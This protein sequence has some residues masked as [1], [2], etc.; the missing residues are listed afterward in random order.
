MSAT[1]DRGSLIERELGHYRIVEKIGD[2]GM[3]EVFRAQD[4][5]LGHDVALKVLSPGPDDRARHTFRKEADALS[6]LNHPNIVTVFDFDTQEGLDFLVMEYV[7]GVALD[8]KVRQGPLPERE[9]VRIGVQLAQGLAAA[10]ERGVIHRD[11]K[12]G[13]LR[14]TD[15]DRLKILDFG[16]AR[17]ISCLDPLAST[18]S[19]AGGETLAGTVRYMAPEQ[20]RGEAV[21]ARTDI[22]SAGA[23]LH[24]LATGNP[25]FAQTL[26]PL[27]IDDILHH[28]P[29]IP[30]GVRRR[31]SPRFEAIILKCLAKEPGQRYQS[32]KDLQAALQQL[33]DSGL[34]PRSLFRIRTRRLASSLL[35]ALFAVA[36]LVAALL[37]GWK[38]WSNRAAT[39]SVPTIDAL[40]VLPLSNLSGDPSQD[41]LA[42][43]MTE[44]LITDLGQIH[45]FDRIISFTSAMMFKSKHVPL[46]EI[47]RQLQVDAVIEGS[48]VRSEKRVQVTI[49][50]VNS[51]DTQLWS[52][53][54]QREFRDLLTLQGELTLAIAH[55][56]KMNVTAGEKA[57]LSTARPVETAA[58]EAYFKAKY[59]INGTAEQR[60]KSRQYFEQA[61]QLDPDY[62]AAYAGLA[63]SYWIDIDLPAR[64]AMPKA[65]KYALKAISLDENLAHAHTA[66]ASVR[67]YGDW[68]WPGADREYQRA[69]QLNPNDAE[70]RR[71]YSVFL[72][73]MGRADQAWTQ[74]Q[75]A[76]ELDPLYLDNATTAG[77]VLYCAHQYDQA[78]GQCRKALELAPNY[79]SSHAC[80]SYAYL[81]KGQRRQAL[82]EGKKAW[83]LSGESIRAVLLGR[84]EAA[85]GNKAE[86]RQILSRLLARSRQTYVPPYFVAVLYA[87][88][89][90]N[91]SALQ[92]LE[93]AYG[94]RDLYLAWIKVDPAVDSLRADVRFQQLLTKMGLASG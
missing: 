58:Q 83:A 86:A 85:A 43:G 51:A 54:Y 18:E 31:I 91:A 8:E 70:A 53:T 28:D 92:W 72:S 37:A 56:I 7:P 26:S 78:M 2:G 19:F 90:D 65:R 93:K 57:Q 21:D 79:D 5:H 82:D 17:S 11:L 80:M 50:L 22:Y 6:K 59:L 75:T 12:P 44:S 30:D 55:E 76:Q 64:E 25:P 47:A 77:W 40:A 45:A 39:Q 61:V 20:L 33:A 87:A 23:V 41:Y 13:N 73:A 15:D 46:P 4:K 16:L 81:G 24:E 94:E 69:L 1:L 38:W 9:A 63:D 34:E 14:L 42:D 62:A 35:M 60:A 88:L 29:A 74:L 67:F 27:L 52:H 3:G 66:L 36:V 84:T 10:H 71:M 32:A 89:D 48:V 68:D 49:R